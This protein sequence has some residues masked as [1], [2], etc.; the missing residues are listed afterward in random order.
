[1]TPQGGSGYGTIYRIDIP[2]DFNSCPGIQAAG[3]RLES[4]LNGD[5]YVD[6]LDLKIIADNW[7]RN[8]CS[9]PDYCHG[10]DIEHNGSV[11]FIDF[12]EFAPQWMQ[13]NDPAVPGFIQNW[14]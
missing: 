7:L 13:Y 11:D 2:P 4:D 14:P 5:C 10:A 9:S 3:Y 6:Y 8:N 12:S 1:M